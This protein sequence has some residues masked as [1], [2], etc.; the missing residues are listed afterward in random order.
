MGGRGEVDLALGRARWRHVVNTVMTIR[1]SV[2]CGPSETVE[3]SFHP[4]GPSRHASAVPR[5][6]CV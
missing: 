6:L 2:K 1:G 3:G 4:V 5:G